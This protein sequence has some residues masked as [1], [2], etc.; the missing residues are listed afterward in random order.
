MRTIKQLLEVML[1]NQEYFCFGLCGWTRDLYFY[2]KI[3]CEEKR[4]MESYIDNNKPSIFS[5][6]DS[7][8]TQLKTGYYWKS[9]DITPRIKWINKHIKRN[10]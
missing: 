8:R 2:D 1:Q 10:S 3:T 4:I 7:F 9:G 5:S 6:L